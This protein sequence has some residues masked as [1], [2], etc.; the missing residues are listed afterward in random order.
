MPGLLNPRFSNYMFKFPPDFFYPEVIQ[1]YNIYLNAIRTPFRTLSDY[2]THCVQNFSWP[3]I[4]AEKTEQIF[5]DIHKVYKPGWPAVRFI[6]HE[7]N[8]TFKATDGFLS[9]FIMQ[10]QLQ[11]YLELGPKDEMFLPNFVLRILDYHGLQTMSMLFEDIVFLT[12]SE[13]ELS[14][15]RNE[16]EFQTFTAGFSYKRLNIQKELQ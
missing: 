4:S 2:M 5:K 12:L 1:K 9:Y 10:D 15:T 8:I 16:F 7:M 14:F 11:R 13:F 6:P 3:A